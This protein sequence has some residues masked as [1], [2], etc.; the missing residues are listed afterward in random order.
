M[1]LLGPFSVVQF[2]NLRAYSARIS[3]RL[4]ESTYNRWKEDF[5][6][7]RNALGNRYRNPIRRFSDKVVQIILAPFRAVSRVQ[8][9]VSVRIR[10]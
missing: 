5:E 1:S 8:I 6:T 9:S 3:N 10:P 7:P 4:K 2:G